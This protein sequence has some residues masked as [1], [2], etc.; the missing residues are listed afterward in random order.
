[1]IR[2]KNYHL[3]GSFGGA[4]FF[5][6]DDRF[7]LS[8]FHSDESGQF[9]S[10]VVINVDSCF[11]SINSEGQLVFNKNLINSLEGF[12]VKNAVLVTE[13]PMTCRNYNILSSAKGY[14][15]Q[16]GIVT[17]MVV[18]PSD[19][20]VFYRK[21]VKDYFKDLSSLEVKHESTDKS[22]FELIETIKYFC[23]ATFRKP[24][25]GQSY[26]YSIKEDGFD[27]DG[28]YYFSGKDGFDE[29]G[30]LCRMADITRS[31]YF[32]E[33]YPSLRLMLVSLILKE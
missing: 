26:Y 19:L 30:G 2:A 9:K 16:H 11:Y 10:N 1:M 13:K 15:R 27:E 28:Y 29:D 23:L 31:I 5:R 20:Y 7:P 8:R 3:G 21:A 22:K 4:C 33:I 6:C 14:M 18:S 32:N 25:L 24:I 12:S 17:L